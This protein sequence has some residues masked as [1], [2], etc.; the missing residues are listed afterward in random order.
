MHIDSSLNELEAADFADMVRT[1]FIILSHINAHL[2][3]RECYLVVTK[4]LKSYVDFLGFHSTI[5]K[6][7]ENTYHIYFS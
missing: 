5:L 6:S 3:V 7:Y 2:I 4:K 1:G